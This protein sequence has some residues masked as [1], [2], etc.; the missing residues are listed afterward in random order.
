MSLHAL[1]MMAKAGDGGPACG[2]GDRSGGSLASREAFAAPGSSGGNGSL[3][4]E[5]V[6]ALWAALE[7]RAPQHRPGLLCCHVLGLAGGSRGSGFAA[8]LVPLPEGKALQGDQ[9]SF[10][11]GCES[12]FVALYRMSASQITKGQVGVEPDGPSCPDLPKLSCIASS[13][14]CRCNASAKVKFP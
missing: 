7:P 3:T 4:G 5:A 6:Q 12:L 2:A 14:C 8:R 1:P 9:A 13:H 10:P 11:V